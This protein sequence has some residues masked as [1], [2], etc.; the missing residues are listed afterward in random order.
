MRERK[1]MYK[2]LLRSFLLDQEAQRKRK[3]EK[4]LTIQSDFGKW[5]VLGT[6][7]HFLVCMYTQRTSYSQLNDGKKMTTILLFFF[8]WHLSEVSFAYYL[9]TQKTNLI[10]S[11][12]FQN[13][14]SRHTNFEFYILD[15]TF[16][17]N[18][19]FKIIFKL[20]KVFSV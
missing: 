14:S 10:Y 2:Q 6:F 20:R 18:F 5:V 11:I 4:C 19:E 17:S 8:S 13:F 12:N 7:Q 15:K 1:E 3:K 9:Q 16:S